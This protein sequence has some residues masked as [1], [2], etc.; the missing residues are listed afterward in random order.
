MDSQ[1][2]QEFDEGF[3]KYIAPYNQNTTNISLFGSE[4][5]ITTPIRLWL[6]KCLDILLSENEDYGMMDEEVLEECEEDGVNMRLLDLYL[7]EI[8]SDF[9]YGEEIYYYDIFRKIWFRIRDSDHKSDL[10]ETLNKQLEESRSVCT[11]GK[12]SRLVSVLSGVFTDMEMNIS[13]SEFINNLIIEIK[14]QYIDNKHNYRDTVNKIKE[15]YEYRKL[16]IDQSILSEILN[17]RNV[18]MHN[19][20]FKIYVKFTDNNIKYEEIKQKL[21]PIFMYNNASLKEKEFYIKKFDDKQSDII[22]KNICNSIYSFFIRLKI[23]IDA[24]NS[25][26][27]LITCIWIL[28]TIY[29]I[30]T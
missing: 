30:S 7:N 5:V 19:D 11:T 18:K 9:E 3:N 28:I 8:Y 2:I 25:V 26:L 27:V 21:I 6:Y 20:I 4:N 22:W 14:N 15:L 29:K 23:C 17:I 24:I 16:D 10:I 12:V 1:L 13:S